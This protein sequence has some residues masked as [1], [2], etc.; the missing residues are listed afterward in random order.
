MAKETNY[1]KIQR[2]NS[3]K[4][5]DDEII[6]SSYIDERNCDESGTLWSIDYRIGIDRTLAC[7]S[8]IDWFLN[9][10][11]VNVSEISGDITANRN[12]SSASNSA[13]ATT[14]AG[15]IAI[16]K[17]L[18][19][20]PTLTGRFIQKI[21]E[22]YMMNGITKSNGNYLKAYLDG[23]FH[24]QTILTNSETGF[25]I[26]IT[27]LELKVTTL[28]DPFSVNWNGDEPSYTLSA[29]IERDPIVE[30]RGEFPENFGK[31]KG[32]EGIAFSTENMEVTN[33]TI[34]G[35]EIFDPSNYLDKKYIKFRIANEDGTVTLEGSQLVDEAIDV[36][37]LEEGEYTLEL[38]L[39]MA[40]NITNMNATYW[41]YFEKIYISAEETSKVITH[42]VDM[43]GVQVSAPMEFV[44]K[45]GNSY[46]TMSQDV[47]GFTLK[48]N[49]LPENEKGKFKKGVT[50]V[51]YIYTEELED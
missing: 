31:P 16:A 47:D 45:V 13:Y 18:T 28:T 4:A 43:D 36:S 49:A 25:Q 48:T 24:A 34:S 17:E 46:A 22:I 8:L 10:I 23:K 7:F 50:D 1:E 38:G 5:V 21:Q 32:F 42:Y 51:Y 44:G 6:K 30:F 39:P 29:N 20:T 12:D 33:T 11:D 27:N 26:I 35:I 15:T 40:D 14:T 3:P 37:S 9:G 2:L 19:I 41:Q